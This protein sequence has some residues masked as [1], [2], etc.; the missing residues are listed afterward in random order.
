MV[1][2][3]PLD[4]TRAFVEDGR[5]E[6]LRHRVFARHNRSHDARLRRVGQI[7]VAALVL[8]IERSVLNQNLYLLLFY[9]F[10]RA[11]A[12]RSFP[13]DGQ[14]HAVRHNLALADVHVGLVDLQV[15]H[16]VFRCPQGNN[17]D[18]GAARANAVVDC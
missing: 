18:S 3:L 7:E 8:R 4:H 14:L 12:P 16:T 17:I 9:S 13:A 5:L 6:M 11:D 1:L 10:D 2:G 15:V